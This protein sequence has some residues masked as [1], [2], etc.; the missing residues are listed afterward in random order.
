MST[1]SP[2]G[3]AADAPHMGAASGSDANPI[4]G[5]MISPGKSARSFARPTAASSARSSA[6]PRAIG[7]ANLRQISNLAVPGAFG[8]EQQGY[9]ADSDDDEA[10]RRLSVPAL[11]HRSDAQRTDNPFIYQAEDGDHTGYAGSPPVWDPLPPPTR[12]TE[13]TTSKPARKVTGYVI[14]KTDVPQGSQPTL[15]AYEYDANGEPML[16][17]ELNE[18][19]IK[20][21]TTET[22]E[23]LP[24][25]L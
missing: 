16:V 8:N 6:L 25:L 7:S 18:A 3:N 23:T 20:S 4:A 21:S 9:D 17:G 12:H 13:G 1:Q 5:A 19:F 22:G 10:D 11:R 2:D 15:A 14:P 24:A